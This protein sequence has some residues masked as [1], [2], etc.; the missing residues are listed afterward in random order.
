M[1][2]CLPYTLYSF[3]VKSYFCEELIFVSFLKHMYM[4]INNVQAI[5]V[6]MAI[7]FLYIQSTKVSPHR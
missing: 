6:C 7:Q 5:N 2:L 3:T 4:P 1:M